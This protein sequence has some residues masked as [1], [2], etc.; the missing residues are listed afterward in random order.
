MSRLLASKKDRG[1]ISCSPVA[2]WEEF[3]SISPS[4]LLFM[5][6]K[7]YTIMILFN[8][9]ASIRELIRLKKNELMVLQICKEEGLSDEQAE[10]IR[11][12]IQCE[13]GF[14]DRAVNKNTD[15][16]QTTDY[17][18]CQY[19]DYWY[20]HLITPTEAL[21]NPEMAVRLM[22]GQYKKGQLKDWVCYK[23]GLY[24]RYL[25]KVD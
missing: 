16:K 23:N 5:E 22:V 8:L 10:L 2:R 7:T 6:L 15:A 17:G 1:R 24:R 13:S 11:A 21:N 19:N 3:P 9:I 4:I 12:V 25:Q 20:R 18:I 14:D